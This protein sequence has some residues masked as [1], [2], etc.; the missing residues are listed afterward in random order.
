LFVPAPFS[1]LRP[2]LIRNAT[3]MDAQLQ[4]SDLLPYVNAS[5]LRYPTYP[6]AAALRWRYI[7]NVTLFADE[8][9]CPR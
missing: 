9:R 5:S 8:R 1:D 4:W 7:K 3:D 2:T 6:H